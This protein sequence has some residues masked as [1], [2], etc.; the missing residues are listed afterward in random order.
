MCGLLEHEPCTNASYYL[1]HSEDYSCVEFPKE[2]CKSTDFDSLLPGDRFIVELSSDSGPGLGV[3]ASFPAQYSF[4][5]DAVVS[6]KVECAAV[7]E[8]TVVE[9]KIQPVEGVDFSE[10][11]ADEAI[12][13]DGVYVPLESLT[14]GYATISAKEKG[15]ARAIYTYNPRA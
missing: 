11:Y 9:G 6:E 7:I 13:E 10:L 15:L 12:G 1:Y 4:S 14:K 3:K 2:S 5:A 8:I